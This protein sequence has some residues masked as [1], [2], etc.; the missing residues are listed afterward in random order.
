MAW[1]LRAQD[2]PGKEGDPPAWGG[3]GIQEEAGEIRRLGWVP[4]TGIERLKHIS[5]RQMFLY[6]SIFRETDGFI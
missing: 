3:V 6:L 4:G 5:G 1:T 2:G